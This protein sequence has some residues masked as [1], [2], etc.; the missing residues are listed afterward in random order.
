VPTQTKRRVLEPADTF[1]VEDVATLKAF[2]DPLRV[3]LLIE[4]TDEPKTV[5]Q[6]A[7]ALGV[8]A[9]RL[10]Y[11]VRILLKHKL[12]RVAGRR[13]VSGIEERRYLATAKS[14]NVNS[15]KLASAAMRTGVFKAMFDMTA[16][17]LEIVLRDESTPLG[18]PGSAVPTLA[19]TRLMLSPE[20]VEELQRRL[21]QIML[22]FGSDRPVKGKQEYHAVLAAYRMPRRAD[23]EA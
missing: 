7:A 19:F 10:Y 2:T 11:H 5:K 6:A 9:T 12:I 4:F 22:D 18:E 8:G 1:I 17:E 14:W 20:E 23:E 13:M 3:R 16:A 15:P 21:E